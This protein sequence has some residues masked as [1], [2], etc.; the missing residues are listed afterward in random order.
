MFPE[1][2]QILANQPSEVWLR[3]S[4]PVDQSTTSL[5]VKDQSKARVDN[6]NVRVE[7]ARKATVGL[8]PGLP[9]GAYTV[10]WETLSS[11]DGH[12]TKG[13]W[14]FGVG[15]ATITDAGGYEQPPLTVDAVLG[16]TSAFLGLALLV[17]VVALRLGVLPTDMHAKAGGLLRRLGLTGASLQIIGLVMLTSNQALQS[18]LDAWT[19]VWQTEFG[20]GLLWRLLMAA[21]L[22]PLLAIDK[23]NLRRWDEGLDAIAIGVLV[24]VTGMFSHTAAAALPWG[25]GVLLDTVHLLAMAAWAGGVIVLH[26]VLRG[27]LVGE[28]DVPLLARISK[29]F[30]LLA[31]CAIAALTVTGTV[32]ALAL[33]EWSLAGIPRHLE[34]DYGL[35]LALKV[36]AAF[37]MMGFGAANHFLYVRKYLEGRGAGTKAPFARNVLREGLVGV[38]VILLAGMLTNLSPAALPPEPPKPWVQQAEGSDHHF[39]LSISPPPQ[40]QAYSS[41]EVRI[42]TDAGQPV[43]DAFR[44][45]FTFEPP[46][47]GLGSTDLLA[48]PKGDGRYAVEGA[49]LG[50]P[51]TWRLTV[52]VQTPSVYSDSVVFDIEVE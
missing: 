36:G 1:P 2:G 40:V 17:G 7:G 29:R 41:Y 3:F 42:T 15:N 6:G 31:I 13:S 50:G 30:S 27:P 34:T 8:Q 19:Y 14:T 52:S 23:R 12:K 4:E 21:G 37:A 51:G 48:T 5:V 44:V 35:L 25:V 16:K 46:D 10:V 20:R 22:V 11:V 43:N 18:G 26:L 47:A 33:F 49:Y 24:L 9:E 39:V 32:M 38:T 28:H 45:R